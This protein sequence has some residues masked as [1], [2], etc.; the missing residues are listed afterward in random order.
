MPLC[1]PFRAA[2]GAVRDEGGFKPASPECGWATQICT[3]QIDDATFLPELEE[4]HL[5]TKARI[6]KLVLFLA[7][8]LVWQSAQRLRQV[9]KQMSAVTNACFQNL[10]LLLLIGNA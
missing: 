5:G 10:H 2:T 9:V 6:P 4:L 8:L 7:D 1:L 3:D